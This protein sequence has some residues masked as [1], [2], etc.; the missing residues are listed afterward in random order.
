[1][2]LTSLLLL[3]ALVY[4]GVYLYRYLIGYGDLLDLPKQMGLNLF[5][6]IA[7]VFF[8]TAVVSLILL[9]REKPEQPDQEYSLTPEF[10][11]ED[12]PVTYDLNTLSMPR[13]PETAKTEEDVSREEDPEYVTALKQ[14]CEYSTN[15]KYELSLVL[16]NLEPS[17]DQTDFD[18]FSKRIADH[19]QDTAFIYG[20]EVK[21]T[22]V[23][24]MPFYS[25]DE[26]KQEL[27]S[28]YKSLKSDLD[29]RS[30]I[31]RAGF[32][33]KFSRYIDAYTMLNESESA[34]EKVTETP[35][36]GILGFE[37][38]LDAYQQYYSG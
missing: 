6:T 30:V 4:T 26:V 16:M 32:T 31:F 17:H 14:E 15:N 11:Q 36:S 8:F 27:V 13:Q 37:P 22:M 5:V 10:L 9:S 1:M 23:I 20:Y 12:Q 25:F 33:S 2:I 3:A 28:L 24:I 35:Q 29:R 34:F 18:R 7:P 19:F 21:N 38:D